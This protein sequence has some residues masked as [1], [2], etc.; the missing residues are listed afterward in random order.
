MN[1]LAFALVVTTAALWIPASDALA[2][3]LDSADVMSVDGTGL[4]E[5]VKLHASGR[6]GDDTYIDAGQYMITYQGQVYAA[7]CVDLDQYAG[8]SGVTEW[9]VDDLPQNGSLV[10]FLM[11]EYAWQAGGGDGLEAAALA[12]SIWEVMY[13]S[14]PLPFDILDGGVSISRNDAVAALANTY[15]HSLPVEPYVS[16]HLPTVLH[17]ADRQ[18]MLIYIWPQVP[19]PATMGLLGVGGVFMALR[20][21]R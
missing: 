11:E 4:H 21:K 17:S 14:D 13:E 10:A 16:A 3:P 6:L 8:T 1:R 19:E 7:Y 5:S 2:G 9:G 12:V 18:D 15:L 20:R